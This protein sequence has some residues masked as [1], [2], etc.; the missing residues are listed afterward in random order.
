MNEKLKYNDRFVIITDCI[1][2]FL[3]IAAQLAF[4]WLIN[5]IGLTIDIRA[6]F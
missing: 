1:A 2:A 3:F 4:A 6:Y 5:K